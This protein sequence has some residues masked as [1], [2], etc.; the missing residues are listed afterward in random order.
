MYVAAWD[1]LLCARGPRDMAEEAQG[2]DSSTWMGVQTKG[3]KETMV[4]GR[5]GDS[6]TW[7]GVQTKGRK[8]MKGRNIEAS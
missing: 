3:R 1:L 2:G 5:K 7:M 4:K 6:P 8:C